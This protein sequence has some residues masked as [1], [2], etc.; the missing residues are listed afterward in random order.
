M[1]R[2]A[3]PSGIPGALS[4]QPPVPATA[5]LT[6]ASAPLQA[7]G[8]AAA[9]ASARRDN[10]DE[11]RGRQDRARDAQRQRH[12]QA[13]QRRGGGQPPRGHRRQGQDHQH[14]AVERRD[15][16]ADR[17]GAARASASARS[18]ATRSRSINAPFRAEALPKVDAAPMWQQPWLLDLVRAAAVPAALVLV[19]LLVISGVIKPALQ[20][21]GE[22]AGGRPAQRGGRRRRRSSASAVPLA[23]AC[24]GN[25]KQ[26]TD[27]RAA[28][29]AEPGRGGAHRARLGQ[30]RRRLI[31]H[32]Q[33][34]RTMD[35]KGTEDAAILLMS[36]GEEQAAE[37]FKHLAPKEVQR[38]ARPSPG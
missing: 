16:Q 31:R 25:D 18:A 15:G 33:R 2:A 35:D 36:L 20:G 17:A 27:A 22:S 5:P 11:L 14:A 8:G 32:A 3:T 13:A 34:F 24:A 7:A 26:S 28:R 12:R 4:N 1:A 21:R 37:V 23:L 30:Q 29:Q 6:G 38:S 19:A 10:V 9:N